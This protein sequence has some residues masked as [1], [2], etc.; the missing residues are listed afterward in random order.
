CL[1][2][3]VQRLDQLAQRAAQAVDLVEQ[4]HGDI[5]ACLVDPHR[6][7]EIEDQATARD[8]H[9][10]KLPSFLRRPRNDPALFDPDVKHGHVDLQADTEFKLVHGHAPMFF[11]GSYVLPASQPSTKAVRA[12]SAPSGSTTF[13]VA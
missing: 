6:I 13:N 11:L 10:A 5:D 4:I 1:I 2:F 7:D 9:F 8:I 12:A 3:R